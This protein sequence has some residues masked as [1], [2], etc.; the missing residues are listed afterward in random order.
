MA[1][2]GIAAADAH[3]GERGAPKLRQRWHWAKCCAPLY[4]C[5]SG[6]VESGDAKIAFF[7]E[8]T[9]RRL[10]TGW[11]KQS[12]EKNRTVSLCHE[13]GPGDCDNVAGNEFF[14]NLIE[15]LHIRLGA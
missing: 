4:V 12:L 10:N 15:G 11:T 5:H 2:V 1:A 3:P 13:D 14:G 7:F 8:A 6:M 9:R